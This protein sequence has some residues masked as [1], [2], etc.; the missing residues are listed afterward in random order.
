MSI[1]IVILQVKV[2]L[3]VMATFQGL[4]QGQGR[5]KGQI[6]STRSYQMSR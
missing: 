5:Y 1:T 6:Q 3:M 4:F 2:I